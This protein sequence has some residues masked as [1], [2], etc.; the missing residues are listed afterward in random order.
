MLTLY[1]GTRSV[2]SAKARI[3][4]AEKDLAYDSRIVDLYAGEQFVP[5]YLKLNP[6]AVVPTLVDD[7]G[8]IIESSVIIQ[9]V[10]DISSQ[11]RLMPRDAHDAA[12]A[13]RYLLR[14]LEIHSATNTFTFATAG[15]LRELK[16]SAAEREAYYRQM[17]DPAM[18]AKRKDL[19]DNGVDSPHVDKAIHIFAQLFK[20]MA[21]DL[22]SSG[23]GWIFGDFSL[24][25]I[26]LIAY[27]DRL[28]RL[29][30]DGFW[31]SSHPCI[32]QWLGRFKLRASY[33]SEI[34]A[35]NNPAHTP[36]V[37]RPETGREAWPSIGARLE[38][39]QPALRS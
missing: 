26:A 24:A 23:G 1:H 21:S 13:R 25:D 9:Y 4:L 39:L 17:P 38:A 27:V 31:A 35:Y 29:G 18:S 30:L 28:D 34:D 14:C 32:T 20:D 22:S 8:P 2:C 16:K 12:L 19:I 33:A 5:A 10:D 36:D 37:Y 7:R 6:M 11:N 15:R 3:A